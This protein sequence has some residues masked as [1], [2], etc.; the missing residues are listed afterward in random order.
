MDFRNCATVVTKSE[1]SAVSG[2]VA[3]PSWVHPQIAGGLSYL[4]LS[5]SMCGGPIGAKAKHC[6]RGTTQVGKDLINV[7]QTLKNVTMQPVRMFLFCGVSH[8]IDCRLPWWLLVI[9]TVDW[10]FADPVDCHNFKSFIFCRL[11][12]CLL[13]VLLIIICIVQF[14]CTHHL[15][16]CVADLFQVTMLRATSFGPCISS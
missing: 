2:F 11:S 3:F 12:W 6:L 4:F 5:S 16:F 7:A 13:I 8:F 1:E 14:D 15:V 10:Q 9:C